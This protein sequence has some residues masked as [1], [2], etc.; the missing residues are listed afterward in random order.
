MCRLQE[1]ELW[2]PLF[3]LSDTLQK[4]LTIPSH[5][6]RSQL[7]YFSVYIRQLRVTDRKLLLRL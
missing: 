7:D 2:I 5:E 4:L 1:I 3:P 6:L